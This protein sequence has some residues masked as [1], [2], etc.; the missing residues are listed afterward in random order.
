MKHSSYIL[1]NLNGKHWT[2][3]T[4]STCWIRFGSVLQ[5]VLAHCWTLICQ[6]GARWN[7]RPS[8]SQ[9]SHRGQLYLGILGTFVPLKALNHCCH[10]NHWNDCFHYSVWH[11]AFPGSGSMSLSLLSTSDHLVRRLLFA[12]RSCWGLPGREKIKPNFSLIWD[13]STYIW[14]TDSLNRNF[15]A[16]IDSEGFVW[17]RWGHI[18]LLAL[19]KLDQKWKPQVPEIVEFW[20]SCPHVAWSFDCWVIGQ[21]QYAR[22]IMKDKSGEVPWWYDYGKDWQVP[23]KAALSPNRFDIVSLCSSS[24]LFIWYL[25]HVSWCLFT[26]S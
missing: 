20:L 18:A 9:Y 14:P 1:L 22:R 4:P 25:P 24:A 17:N 16:K 10:L 11:S 2:C 5:F 21:N 3:S 8:S 6:C 23:T 15:W 13:Y 26:M 12:S 19:P 7:L